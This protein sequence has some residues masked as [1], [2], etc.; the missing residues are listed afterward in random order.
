M[1][2]VVSNYESDHTRWMREMMASH[3]EWAADQQAG[4]SLWWDKKQEPELRQG[5]ETSKE[6]PK[7]YPYDVNFFGE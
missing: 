1:G 4:R 6:A 3:P 2:I 7:P 5:F